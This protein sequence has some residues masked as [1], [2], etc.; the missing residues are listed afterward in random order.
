MRKS[1]VVDQTVTL[2]NIYRSSHGRLPATL[3]HKSVCVA[4]ATVRWDDERWCTVLRVYRLCRLLLWTC[5]KTL[6]CLSSSAMYQCGEFVERRIAFTAFTAANCICLPSAAS[7]A[8]G[9][10]R[11][12][13]SINQHHVH[14]ASRGLVLYLFQ[15]L[16]TGIFCIMYFK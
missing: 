7:V 9:H 15:Y 14:V 4:A 16:Y 13:N 8:V 6:C 11:T 10:A 12:T 2:S 5:L 1:C 3:T